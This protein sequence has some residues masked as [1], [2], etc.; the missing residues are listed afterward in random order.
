MSHPSD[1][2]PGAIRQIGYVV[3]D[4]DAAMQSWCSLGVGPWLTMRNLEQPNC[5]Y[6]GQPSEPTVS[7]AF[8]NSGPLQ[9]ELIQLHD[10][11]PSIYR[12]FLDAG[13]EGFHQLAWWAEDFDGF[14]QRAE[15]AGWPVVFSGDGNGTTQ[16]AYF[17][18]DTMISTIVE[19]MELN[20]ATRG[21]AD[22]VAN[23][24]AGWDGVTKPVRALF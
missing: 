4:L 12:E 11:G 17:E 10:D 1:I 14:M 6:R 19:V 24:A 18:L 16:F 22:A 2:L 8:A 20:D 21:L 15:A 13:H 23:A 7:I 3:R 5:V 9:V